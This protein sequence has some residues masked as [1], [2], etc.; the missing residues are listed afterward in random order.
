MQEL[1]D[2]AAESLGRR[3]ITASATAG[4]VS[5]E[6]A[7]FCTTQLEDQHTIADIK[8]MENLYKTKQAEVSRYE[9]ALQDARQMSDKALVTKLAK[10]REKA[11]K[12]RNMDRAELQRLH[13]MQHVLLEKAIENFLRCF[14]ACSDFDQHVPKFCAIW[15]KHSKQESLQSIV[16]RFLGS[17]PSY[18]FL[19]LLHQLCSR[20][21][22]G[23]DDFQTSLSDLIARICMDHPFHSLHQILSTV[24]SIGEKGDLVAESRSFAATRLKDHLSRTP[25]LQDLVA[26][27]NV[28]FSAYSDLASIPTQKTDR[29][30]NN[31]IALSSYPT[32]RRFRNLL[33]DLR[34]PPPSLD[35]PVSPDGNY[36]SVP[37]VQQ[38][39]HSFEV[40]GGV[41]QPKILKSMLSD[42]KNVRELV[43]SILDWANNL[44]SK[45]TTT[46]IKT[47]SCSRFFNRW[48]G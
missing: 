3:S 47:L 42:G 39:H 24:S 5:F 22:R 9:V 31:E 19:P 21:S 18:K 11:I 36:S 15:L 17:V 38:Y 33:Q 35:L 34:L 41:N 6:Y 30:V 23:S 40:A 29:R 48:T 7:M 45:A 10:D 44:R 13:R 14:S 28:M 43:C 12:L 46:S 37:Y 20:L 16:V 2:P 26:R 8:R 1:L 27:I 4:K 32:L 25:K